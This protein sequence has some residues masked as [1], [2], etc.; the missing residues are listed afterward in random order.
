VKVDFFR[1][2]LTGADAAAVSDV[3]ESPFLTTGRVARAVEAELAQYFDVPHALLTNSWTNGALALLLALDLA[4]GDEVIVPAMTFIASANVVELAGGTTVFADVDP[5]TLLLTTAGVAGALTARTRAVIPVHLYG[6]MMNVVEL[7]GMLN[8]RAPSVRIV[9]DCAHC[10][11]G[12]FQSSKPGQYSDAAV[13]SFYATKN[14]TCGEGGA[15]VTRDAEL[16]RRTIETRSHGM[17]AIAADRFAGGRYNH[18]DMKR[19]GTKANLPDLLAA[20]LPTQIA[21]VDRRRVE[22]QRL[23]DRY[24]KAFAGGPL[25]LVFQD[26]R[27]KSAEHLF[28][29]GVPGGGRDAAIAALN[30]AGIGVTVNYSS[31]PDTTFYRGRYP[32]AGDRCPISRAWGQ[33]TLSLPLFP[34]LTDLEQDYVIS[35]VVESVYPLVAK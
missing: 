32:D 21:A 9:E 26:S 19:L 20:L 18:W 27:S 22:R 10:F 8:E 34:G 23:A 6:Q 31:V 12:E 7:R 24:R 35:T 29:I 28:V 30:T 13:F 5:G 17:S 15:I 11:E 1:H 16:S 14:V 4:P 33:E 2:P 25:R 3:L